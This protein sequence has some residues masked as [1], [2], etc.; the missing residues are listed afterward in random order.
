MSL[1]VE[2]LAY[3]HIIFQMAFNKALR[4]MLFKLNSRSNRISVNVKDSLSHMLNMVKT[5]GK[6]ML[7]GS[8]QLIINRY[9]L[10]FF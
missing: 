4:L 2:G 7:N 8:I 6:I 10:L 9:F 5:G 1:H 3:T